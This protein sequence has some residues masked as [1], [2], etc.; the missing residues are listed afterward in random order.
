M[1]AC[2]RAAERI[3]SDPEAYA[4]LSALNAVCTQS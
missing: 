1:N 2:R 4:H 3:A